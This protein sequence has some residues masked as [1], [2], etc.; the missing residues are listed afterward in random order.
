MGGELR[1]KAKDWAL[2][3]LVAWLEIHSKKEVFPRRANNEKYAP[4]DKKKSPPKESQSRL[5]A[6]GLNISDVAERDAY[7]FPTLRSLL[8]FASEMT[9]SLLSMPRQPRSN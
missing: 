3:K 7:N 4:R 9:G 5:C 8:G 6:H 2:R 1:W